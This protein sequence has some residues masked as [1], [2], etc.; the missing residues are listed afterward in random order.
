MK[1]NIPTIRSDLD[2][3]LDLSQRLSFSELSTEEVL[4]ASQTILTL[5]RLVLRSSGSESLTPSTKSTPVSI[6][7]TTIYGG[8]HWK[9]D[10]SGYPQGGVIPTHNLN[11]SLIP[12]DGGQESLTTASKD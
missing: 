5:V 10:P 2:Y 3:L 1:T 8:K 12:T 9:Q 4:M 6:D 11:L 7:G